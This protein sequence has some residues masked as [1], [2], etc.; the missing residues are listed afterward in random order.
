LSNLSIALERLAMPA[1]V[2]RCGTSLGFSQAD[3]GHGSGANN[4]KVTPVM[5]IGMGRPSSSGALK[6][7]ATVDERVLMAGSDSK[8]SSSLLTR[9]EIGG[10]M[11]GGTGNDGAGKSQREGITKYF[12]ATPGG[13]RSGGK[14]NVHSG[15]VV[16]GTRGRGSTK[17]V[18]AGTFGFGRSGERAS[19]KTSLPSVAASPVNDGG[20]SKAAADSPAESIDEGEES[21]E[22]GSEGRR[23]EIWNKNASRRASLASQALSQSLSTPSRTIGLPTRAARSSYPQFSPNAK[24]PERRAENDGEVL[25]VLKDCVIFVDVRTDEGDDAGALFVDMLKGMGAKVGCLIPPL[26]RL[27]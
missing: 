9:T 14:I 5:G 4:G 10:V 7:S 16:G 20:K 19:R 21:M 1:P 3:A 25:R 23:K 24:S 17:G 12:A 11:K 22:G 18:T 26:R 13:S 8:A 15:I 2:K 6:R 27:W